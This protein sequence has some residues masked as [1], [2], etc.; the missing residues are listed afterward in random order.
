MCSLGTNISEHS[1]LDL[2]WKKLLPR[3]RLIEYKFLGD[4]PLSIRF[5]PY[6]QISAPGPNQQLQNIVQHGSYSVYHGGDHKR[7]GVASCEELQS[8]DCLS[9]KYVA[10]PSYPY[11]IA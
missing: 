3:E 9:S 2:P 11:E 5:H 6:I 1:E 7:F 10:I 4:Q 8:V